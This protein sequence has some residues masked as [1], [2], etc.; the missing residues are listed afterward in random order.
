MSLFCLPIKA[1]KIPAKI[2][3]RAD[4]VEVWLDHLEDFDLK[5]IKKP[6]LLV[7]RSK[8]E[9]YKKALKFKPAYIDIDLKNKKYIPK[10]LGK[11]KLI[12]SY[13]NY[14]KTPKNLHEIY[15]KMCALK[16]DIIKFSTK[17]NE[18]HDIA[19]LFSLI[20]KADKP[21]ITLGMG[22]KGKITRILAPR[23]GNYLYYAP[24]KAQDATAPGQLTY[25][26]LT[27]YWK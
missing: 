6:L 7:S 2:D 24:I 3:K 1:K 25:D 27:S 14:E 4:I 15:K 19:N 12:I 16:P 13:H 10:N 17:I 8:P 5:K 20:P 9:L 26:E 21:I 18:S 11:T 22:E 23:L